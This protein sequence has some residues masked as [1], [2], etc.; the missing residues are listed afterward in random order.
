MPGIVDSKT[1]WQAIDEAKLCIWPE[2]EL[3]T[4]VRCGTLFGQSVTY[5]GDLHSNVSFSHSSYMVILIRTRGRQQT[6]PA[7]SSTGIRT[8]GDSSSL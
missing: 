2:S 8:L 4:N 7:Y 3:A 1:Y 6:V 5:L